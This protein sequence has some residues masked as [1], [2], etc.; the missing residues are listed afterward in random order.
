MTFDP[1]SIRDTAHRLLQSGESEKAVHLLEQ[2]G[3]ECE[4]NDLFLLAQIHQL[5][6]RL[7][8]GLEYITSAINAGGNQ[9]SEPLCSK[10]IILQKLGRYNEAI[11]AF[12][13]CAA[14]DSTYELMSNSLAMTQKLMGE[15]EK[16]AH[17][18]WQGAR[19]H[20][21]N[22]ITK[23]PNS[24]DT[25]LANRVTGTTHNIWYK[26]LFECMVENSLSDETITGLQRP[27]RST[28][29]HDEVIRSVGGLFWTD[30]NTKD[31]PIQQDAEDGTPLLLFCKRRV[32]H[33]N[34]Y[35]FMWWNCD[36]FFLSTVFGNRS[37][38][39]HEL[40]QHEE[41]IHY[42]EEAVELREIHA[43][44]ASNLT[45]DRFFGCADGINQQV[46]SELFE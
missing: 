4:W 7:D 33:P 24:S 5:S 19:Q 21:K 45:E 1:N 18:Y 32:Y 23:S 27:S 15:Y 38:V 36:H 22:W 42:E 16:A 41:A 30:M 28:V 26:C 44:S 17:N 14:V 25:P 2:L 9:Y 43:K 37:T 40:G 35:R 20:F 31:P 11:E 39:L 46:Y 12:K 10:G 13:A 34:F 29:K 3:P 8:K 6:G